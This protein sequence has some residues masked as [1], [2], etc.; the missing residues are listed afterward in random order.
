[1]EM[2]VKLSSMEQNQ[3]IKQFP[4]LMVGKKIMYVHGFGS[5]A[6]S[7]TVKRLREVFPRTEV[8]A[9]D[10]PV[11]PHEAMALLK[12]VCT[13]EQPDLIIGTS[14]GGMYTEQLY[15]YD[16]ICVNPALRI[17]D[18]MTTH[19]L[20][21]KQQFFSPRQDGIQEFYVD[22]PLVKRYRE[23]QEQGLKPPAGMVEE[24]DRVFGLFGDEDELVDSFD[25]FH[26]HYP[27]AIGFHGGHRITDN[28]FMHYI[29]P[30]IRWIDDRQERRQ[31][32]IVLIAYDTLP[33]SYGHP[34]SSMHKAFELLIEHYQ[35]FVVV[36]TDQTQQARPWIEEHL[37]TPAWHHVVY[38]DRPD[39]LYGDYF[40]TRKKAA[41]LMAT[42]L[43]FGSDEL[44][45]WEDVITFFA[46]LGGQ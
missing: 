11:E 44:K 39:L 37:S 12:T 42:S 30:V 17:A 6:Q 22:K 1:M 25:L 3:Y 28:T 16:R 7:G 32:P 13:D 4:D 29:V 31:R 34:A 38:T 36:P 9:H 41:D 46:R 24:A 26:Q 18:T 43:C 33:D 14:M 15:G 27:Q 5:S 10:L 21:G 40:I 20:T 19:G 45:T 2:A 8:I 23:V 35:V